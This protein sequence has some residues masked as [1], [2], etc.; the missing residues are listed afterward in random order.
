MAEQQ[1]DFPSAEWAAAFRDAINDNPVYAKHAADWTHGSVALVC[2]AEPAVGLHED[3][4]IVLDTHQGRCRDASFAM[5]RQAAE[6][7]DFVIEAS[8]E[9]WREVLAGRIDPIKGMMQGK[10]RLTKGH[11]P[12]MLKYVESSR[13]LVSSAARVPT[14]FRERLA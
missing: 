5:G 14:R 6:R 12:T 8:Y 10:L 3:A 13:A 4:V 7:A 9:R 11:L 2:H 1:I